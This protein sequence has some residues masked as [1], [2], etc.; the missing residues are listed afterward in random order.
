MAQQPKG[1]RPP[2]PLTT[3]VPSGGTS[4]S[5]FLSQSPMCICEHAYVYHVNACMHARHIHCLLLLPLEHH[6]GIISYQDTKSVLTISF[7][8]DRVCHCMDVLYSIN[9]PSLEHI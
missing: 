9:H 7:K 2:H 5:N 1:L 4:V 6:L 3:Q 8:D